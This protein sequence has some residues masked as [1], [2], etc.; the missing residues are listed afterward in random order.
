MR[1]RGEV[2]DEGE[3]EG[4][5]SVRRQKRGALDLDELLKEVDVVDLI[6]LL[7]HP[8]HQQAQHRHNFYR[9]GGGF[10]TVRYAPVPPR[11]VQF[12]FIFTFN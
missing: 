12:L 2:D 8:T 5:V 1:A 11:Y 9:S 7:S 3:T 6:T 4:R 10:G